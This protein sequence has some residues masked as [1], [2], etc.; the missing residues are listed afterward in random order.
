MG[1]GRSRI[2]QHS[3]YPSMGWCDSPNHVGWDR[4]TSWFDHE[5]SSYD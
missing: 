3:F 2:G 4:G 1:V 5:R